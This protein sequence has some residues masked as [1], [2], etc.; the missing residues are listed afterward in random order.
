MAELSLVTALT[1]GQVP[2]RR[3]PQVKVENHPSDLQLK[4]RAH[5]HSSGQPRVSGLSCAAAR[6][7][8][9][10]LPRRRLQCE[11]AS[12]MDALPP[13]TASPPEGF[14]AQFSHRSV[15]APSRLGRVL[16]HQHPGA[17]LTAWQVFAGAEGK[18]RACALWCTLCPAA[19]THTHTGRPGGGHHCSGHVSLL[20]QHTV[21]SFLKE[22]SVCLLGLFWC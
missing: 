14:G 16:S 6:H 17:G 1:T 18:R 9:V 3:Q 13:S 8:L 7:E 5:F 15:T 22:E 20:E 19:P 2:F 12:E 10:Q 11:G 4:P 21:C